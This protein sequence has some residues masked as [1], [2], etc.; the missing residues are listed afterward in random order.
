MKKHFKKS[1]ALICST[2]VAVSAVSCLSVNAGVVPYICGDVNGDFTIDVRDVTYIQKVLV[3]GLSKPD[4][5]SDTAD[6]YL[7]SVVDIRDATT[8]QEYI[9]GKHTSLPISS[10]KATEAT[11]TVTTAPTT[12]TET[13]KP[14]TDPDGWLLEIIKP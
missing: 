2:I 13:T 7:D 4:N 8:L 3:A 11:T 6:V 10:T 1:V 9:V 14:A 5:F 12:A